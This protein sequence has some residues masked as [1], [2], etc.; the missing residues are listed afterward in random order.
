MEKD[1]TKFYREFERQECPICFEKKRIVYYW[2]QHGVCIDCDGIFI[3]HHINLC[4]ICR[5][6]ISWRSD[7]LGNLICT[8]YT[9]INS[10]CPCEFV[11]RE[12]DGVNF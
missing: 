10:S 2:C 6:K 3:Q 1:S 9:C 11:M 7:I 8:K 12:E 4:P 5:H